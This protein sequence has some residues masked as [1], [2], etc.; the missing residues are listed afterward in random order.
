MN[1]L[2]AWLVAMRPKTLTAS[3]VPVLVGTALAYSI[4]GYVDIT[5][6]LWALLS[7]ICIQIGTNLINDALDF[8]KGADS[9]SRL[10]PKRL[11]QQGIALPSQVLGAGLT[12]LAFAL[13]AGI[14]LVMKAGWPL[15]IIL[16]I[17]VALAYLYT[18]GPYPLA[19]R[20]LGD[21]F[22]FLFFGLVSTAAIFYVQTG[23]LGPM[24]LL[25]GAQVGLLATVLIAINNL[26][27][28]EGDAAA[29][30]RTL[31]VRFGMLFGRIEITLLLFAP[32]ALGYLWNGF[33]YDMPSWLPIATLPLAGKI[34]RSV[35]S[36]P[37]SAKYNDFLAQSAL[38][39]ILFAFTL[40]IA[41]LLS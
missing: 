40:S 12:F 26:R 4:Q 19:Y 5:L 24:A 22:V 33:G 37:P 21:L 31:A 6:A 8:K 11:I 9:P 38:L 29:S 3:F 1:K 16:L 30:K 32:F 10:G 13:L 17:S 28:I 34:A 39:Q 25:A 27:D 35:W 18:G 2:I 15:L 20:G 23:Y 7:A 14:P 41:Y 36:T